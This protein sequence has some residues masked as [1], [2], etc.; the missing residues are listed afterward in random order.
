MLRKY[1]IVSES[2]LA[3]FLK[4]TNISEALVTV[5]QPQVLIGASFYI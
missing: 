4:S 3:S 2:T 5:K 1:Q